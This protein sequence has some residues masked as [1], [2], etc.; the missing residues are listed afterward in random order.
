[1]FPDATDP[2]SDQ[3]LLQKIIAGDEEA[4][5]QLYHRYQPMIYNY[6]LRLIH[7]KNAAEELLQD[8]FLATWQGARKFRGQSSVKTWIFR[9]AHYKAVSWLRKHQKANQT[10]EFSPDLLIASPEPSPE[11][12]LI[13]KAEIGRVLMALDTLSA[14][15]R[16]VV[17]LTFVH[18]FAYQQ[19]AEIMGC[20][21]GTVKSRMSYALKYMNTELARRED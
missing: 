14:S 13:D 18:G 15:H 2:L 4:F 16:A 7:Q 3:E 5:Q 17:E 8:T 1:M 21:V 11:K 10:T 12:N 6:I 9:I 19:I 20:P